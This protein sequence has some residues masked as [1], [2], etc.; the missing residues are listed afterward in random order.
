V[1][2]LASLQRQFFD[3]VTAGVA[4]DGLIA[5]GELEVYASMYISRLLDAI[6]DEYPKLHKALGHEAFHT[7]AEDYLRAH[8]PRSFS[9]REAG[10]F[11]AD[12]LRHSELA[13]PWAAD[14]A[15]LERARH[16]IFDGPDAAPL[17]QPD[18]VAQG[19][20]LPALVV[21]WVPSSA[22]VPLR[23]TVD[24]LWSAIEDEQAFTEP[25]REPRTVLVWRS[26]IAVLHRTLDPDE[27]E[28]AP[29]ISRGVSFAEICEVLAGIHGE[30]ASPRAAELLLL[31]L[32]G[33]ALIAAAAPADQPVG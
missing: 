11:V 31:W 28:L 19:A 2:D 13:P 25:A 16:E 8:P 12:H 27:A 6:A 21:R 7:V 3:R 29:S 5:S 1:A 20:E 18:V 15:A 9:L 22:V 32:A 10:A 30:D 26:D 23:W 14:L 24:D 33:E 4:T 17:T